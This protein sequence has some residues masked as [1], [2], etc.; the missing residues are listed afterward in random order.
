MPQGVVERR[1]ELGVLRLHEIPFVGDDDDAASGAIRFAADRRVLIAGAG[2]R[3]MRSAT[4]S[5]SAIASLA[6][7]TLTISTFPPPETRPGRR[8]P[9]VSMIRSGGDATQ[10]GIDRI[11]GGARHVADEHALLAKQPVHERRLPDIGTADDRDA[12]L[13][14]G[15]AIGTGDW[16]LGTRRLLST[17]VW[18]ESPGP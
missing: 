9:A 13:S 10:R 7:A 4:T 5:A 15:V 2:F 18:P 17:R 12:G 6:S 1:D 16:G 14:I 11:P 3:S 8:M